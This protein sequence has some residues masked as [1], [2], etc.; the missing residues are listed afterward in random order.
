MMM[1]VCSRKMKVARLI[2]IIFSRTT[3]NAP[4]SATLTDVC[5][6]LSSRLDNVIGANRLHL[7]IY[8]YI[9]VYVCVCRKYV[10]LSPCA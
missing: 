10:R 3:D 6:T 9:Y 8:I 2:G 1:F 5:T 4:V 7:S